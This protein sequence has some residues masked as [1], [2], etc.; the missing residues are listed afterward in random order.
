MLTRHHR[1]LIA[2]VVVLL[3]G[4]GLYAVPP[5][6]AADPIP[7][8]TRVFHSSGVGARTI[9][10]DARVRSAAGVPTGTITFYAVGDTE[11]L[12]DPIPV[13]AGGHAKIIVGT[14]VCG[15]FGCSHAV[16]RA[17]FTGTGGYADSE[18]NENDGLP[19]KIVP[20]PTILGLGGPSLLTLPLT[21]SVR[22]YYNDG[23]PAE[24]SQ[25]MF[26]Y[27]SAWGTAGSNF[28]CFAPSDINGLASCKG[29]GGQAAVMSL[30][31][32]GTFAAVLPPN[33]QPPFQVVKLPVIAVLK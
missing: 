9:G 28:V 15:P 22:T 10:L 20:Q 13:D 12:E 3:A 31:G 1:T 7:T 16:Y 23:T 32:T 30:L 27:G 11:P 6:Q 18:G 8:T 5:V 19:I 2:F 4:I 26:S 29:S 25:A 14:D 33:G 24:G 21:T 17:V